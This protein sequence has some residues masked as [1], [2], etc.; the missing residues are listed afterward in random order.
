MDAKN[1]KK[2][3]PF[4]PYVA[5]QKYAVKADNLR[6]FCDRYHRPGAYHDR[7][8]E[9]MEYDYEG[10]KKEMEREGFTFI[11]QGSSTTGGVV[12]YYGKI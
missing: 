9:Y 3:E 7:G 2:K 8:E 10:H 1:A 11:P 4:D 5:F 6:D 12:S